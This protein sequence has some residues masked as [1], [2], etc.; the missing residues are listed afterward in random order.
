MAS[1]LASGEPRQNNRGHMNARA[2]RIWSS[3][4]FLAGITFLLL[5]SITPACRAAQTDLVSGR[6]GA[7]AEL[8][9]EELMQIAV[10]SVS[11]RPEKLSEAAA[12]I[13]VITQEDIRRSGVTSIPEALRMAPG[14]EVA[15]LL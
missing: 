9:L 14:I 15:T 7:L 1:P 6:P 12:A 5:V 4:K 13:Y 11:K 3:R 2:G 8:S 10:T